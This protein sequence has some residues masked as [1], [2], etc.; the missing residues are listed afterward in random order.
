MA[1]RKSSYLLKHDFFSGCFK[2]ELLNECYER[3]YQ[4]SLCQIVKNVLQN[5]LVVSFKNESLVMTYIN[6]VF[7]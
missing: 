4:V 5:V 6:L 3:S 1:K 2:A 7:L